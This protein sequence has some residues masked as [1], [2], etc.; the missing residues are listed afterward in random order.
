MTEHDLTTPA[1]CDAKQAALVT[2]ITQAQL[3]L[4]RARN[5]ETQAE[6]AYKKARLIAS[7][8]GDCPKVTRGG[9]TVADREDWIDQQAFRAWAEYRS[10][11]TTKEIANDYLRS[12]YAVNDSVRSIGAGH[13]HALS[14]AGA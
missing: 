10:A 8:S 7:H 14:A 5:A 6:I 11:T 12:L 4:G 1:G 2:E 13:R 9:H 3:A